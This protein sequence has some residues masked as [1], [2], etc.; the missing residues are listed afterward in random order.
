MRRTKGYEVI[1]VIT[2]IA[3]ALLCVYLNLFSR[4]QAGDITNIIVNIVM[5]VIVGFILFFSIQ[6][7]LRPVA[8]IAGDL[9]RVTD[10]IENDAKH[11]H[12]FLWEKYSEENE[13]L[14]RD[15]ILI[16]QYQDYQ[17]ELERI[18]HTDKT[19]YKCDIEDYI[20]YDLID[21][22]IHR[23]R[24]N[25][26]AG[27]MTGLGIL[28]TFIGLS[29]GLQSF[30]TGTTAEITNSIEPLMDGIKVAF[31]TSIYGMVFSLVFN[32][33]YKRRLDDAERSVREFLSAYKKYVMPDTA[34]DGVN[35]LMELQQQQTEAILSLSDTVAHQLSEGLKELLEPQFDRFDQ[36]IEN[37]A[38]MATRSQM[39]QLSRVVDVFISELNRCLG[40]SFTQLSDTVNKTLEVQRSNEKQMQEIFEKNVTTADNMD[41]ITKQTG[42][43]AD[44][45]KLFADKVQM[46]ERQTSETLEMLK[47]QGESNQRLLTGAGHYMSDLEAYK[48]SLD[49]SSAAYDKRLLAQEER[50]RDLQKLTEAVPLEVN[51]TFNIIN[52]NLQIVENHFKETIEHINGTLD[53]V[54]EVVDY[55]YRGIEQGFDN[56]SRSLSELNA[57]IGRLEAYYRGRR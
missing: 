10:K 26:V 50:L 22:V 38:N 30:N 24:M 35:R 52:E 40:N 57:A 45:L 21:A 42:M 54:P 1:I 43:V 53:K 55:S 48:K 41:A 8:R 23:D 56:V 27:V 39:E 12:K 29:L 3:M 36:T 31:H 15:R 16:R 44:A 11:T 18:V 7:S 6:G 2:Y 34:T 13:E 5:F 37:F 25:Q 33:V 17:Y 20:G 4:N 51:E 9:T 49:I 28:G 19:Y 46:M 14:F 47:K 32:Y